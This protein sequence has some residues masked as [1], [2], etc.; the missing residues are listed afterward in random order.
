MYIDVENH[1]QNVGGGLCLV[2]GSRVCGVCLG[3]VRQGR[4]VRRADVDS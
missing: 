4:W 2:C 1:P 3:A